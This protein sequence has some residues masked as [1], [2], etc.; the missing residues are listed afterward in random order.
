MSNT[1]PLG[2]FP[3]VVLLIVISTRDTLVSEGISLDSSVA[4]FDLSS[5]GLEEDRIG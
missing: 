1:T 4:G 2:E 5:L 3:S